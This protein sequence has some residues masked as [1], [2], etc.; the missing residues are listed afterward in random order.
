MFYLFSFA[1]KFWNTNINISSYK[2]WLKNGDDLKV[3]N[4]FIKEKQMGSLLFGMY[5]KTY[6]CFHFHS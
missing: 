2:F 1:C 5:Q 3:L 6:A 4:Y